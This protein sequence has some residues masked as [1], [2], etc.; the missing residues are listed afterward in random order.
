[1]NLILAIDEDRDINN[2]IIQWSLNDIFPENI[3]QL[4]T[5]A[6]YSILTNPN[7]QYLAKRAIL[8][9]RNDII[10][11]LNVQL[12]TFMIDELFI[13]YNIDILIDEED[14]ET[15]A[16]KYLNIINLSTLFSHKLNLK[17]DIFIILLY[18]FSIFIK[19]FNKIY[20]Y[21]IYIN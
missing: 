11:N 17:I 7:A 20:F 19:L 16:T 3:S 8:T 12:L 6:I 5:N 10:D 1:M 9:T 18:N 13:F 15:Y 21:F 2:D 14:I 4:L